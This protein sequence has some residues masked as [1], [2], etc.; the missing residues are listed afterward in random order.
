M[1]LADILLPGSATLPG[2]IP[3]PLKFWLAREKYEDL[4]RKKNANIIFGKGEWG[5]NILLWA[6]IH[7]HPCKN[8]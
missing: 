5:K 4:L 6:I 2:K 1:I 8:W 3:V 7:I